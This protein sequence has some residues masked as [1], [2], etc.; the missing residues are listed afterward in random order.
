MHQPCT[1]F[2]HTCTVIFL[3][4][5]VQASSAVRELIKLVF[6]ML[7][8]ALFIWNFVCYKLLCIKATT[9]KSFL[10]DEQLLWN[11]LIRACPTKPGARVLL[12][13]QI[14]D[15]GLTNI[16]NC[17]CNVDTYSSLSLESCTNISLSCPLSWL[18]PI[19][20]HQ[21]TEHWQFETI[22]SLSSSNK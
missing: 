2:L 16:Q 17:G 4:T 14:S 9:A 20:L 11:D 22:I 1:S 15:S 5:R 13:R 6:T 10:S 18:C 21:P 7:H 12:K 3:W 19:L 8:F